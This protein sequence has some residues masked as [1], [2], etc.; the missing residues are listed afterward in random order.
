MTQDLPSR[1]LKPK[2][3]QDG[4]AG[5]IA[6][7]GQ[8][9][10]EDLA[11]GFGV[12]AET[13]RRDLAQLAEE[14]RVQK[15]HGGARRLRLLGEA[16][17]AERLTEN[18]PAKQAIGAK[19]LRE[20]EPGDTIFIDTGSTTLTAAEALAGLDRLTVITNSVRVAQVMAASP[21]GHAVY[22]LGGRY[23][24]A[25]GQSVGPLVLDQIAAFQAD[26]AVLTVTAL[27]PEAGLS[28]ADFDESCVAR[29]MIAHARQVIVLADRSKI[30]RQAAFRVA[31]WDQVDLVLSDSEPDARLAAALAT[32]GTAW[33]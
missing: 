18:A 7:Q 15:V 33:R 25:N 22:L 16:S 14:G 29:A 24:E 21:A 6:R 30:G 2:D 26:H 10:V 27:D 31:R 23:S 4:I 11:A 5:A 20:I 32:A 3:R 12:S 9:T 1:P 17:F 19:L 8:M 28:D 13:I